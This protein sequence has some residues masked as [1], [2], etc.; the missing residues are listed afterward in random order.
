MRRGPPPLPTVLKR[1]KGTLKAS[2]ANP[3]EAVLPAA[4]PHPPAWLDKALHERFYEVAQELYDAGLIARLDYTPIA[5]F[6]I[7]EELVG[8]SDHHW[9]K[10]RPMA[11]LD[12]LLVSNAAS[13]G[14]K[15]NPLL[16]QRLDALRELQRAC[17]ELGMTPSSR[18]RIDAHPPVDEDDPL[19]EFFDPA[20][21]WFK[22]DR[23]RPRLVTGKRR[24]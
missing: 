2:R 23:P 19:S 14:V 10:A 12:G 16:T 5:T 24:N 7:L 8:L 20:A 15:R 6:V 1:V 18:Q 4:I 21:K 3:N 13:P 9:R 17:A 11:A 22:Q